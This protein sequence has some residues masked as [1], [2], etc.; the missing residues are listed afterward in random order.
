M[1]DA[2]SENVFSPVKKYD[3]FNFFETVLV[4]STETKNSD[5]KVVYRATLSTQED[6]EI[7]IENYSMATHTRWNKRYGKPLQQ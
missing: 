1:S 2:T 6:A 7:W 4:E 5:Q 3:K